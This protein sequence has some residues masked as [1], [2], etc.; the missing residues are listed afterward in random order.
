[1]NARRE[2]PPCPCKN[3][4]KLFV[5]RSK[6]NLFCSSRC[7]TAWWKRQAMLKPSRPKKQARPRA[8]V[9]QRQA[10]ATSPRPCKNCGKLFIPKNKQNCFCSSLCSR[11]WK[12]KQLRLK[13]QPKVFPP[14][15]CKNCGQLFVPKSKQNCFCCRHCNRAWQRK[16]LRL[17]H[18]QEKKAVAT[19][20]PKMEPIKPIP[21][22]PCH[23]CGKPTTQFRCPECWAK[24]RE[25]HAE[26][27]I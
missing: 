20:L 3:C 10:K 18:K 25:E 17:R 21:L 24:L 7:C 23:D 19:Q 6:F 15:T 1:M 4:G 9:Q 8:P 26:Y 14:T 13:Y 11:E 2:L 16:Q 5:P 22:R 27:F 12:V